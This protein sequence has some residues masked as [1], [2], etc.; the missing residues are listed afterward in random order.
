MVNQPQNDSASGSGGGGAG[1][2]LSFRIGGDRGDDD[3]AGVWQP[4]AAWFY[5]DGKER[6]GISRQKT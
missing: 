1:G 3:G 5:K 2:V 6:W 4:P